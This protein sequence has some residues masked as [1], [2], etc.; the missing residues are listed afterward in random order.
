M[1]GTTSL[2]LRYPFPSET[3]TAQ[4]YQDLAEDIDSV[5]DTLDALR[6]QAR[7]PEMAIV[8]WPGGG[9]SVTQGVTTT[10]TYGTEVVDTAG[11]A[12]LGV[13][14]DRL[15]LSAGIWLINGWASISGG[16]TTSGTQLQFH[17]NAAL[18][19]F[20]RIDNSSF[21][22]KETNGQALIHVAAAGSILQMNAAWF[23]T[24]GPQT[25]FA[26]LHAWKVREL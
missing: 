13:N 3:V 24:G 11:L 26:S 25:W 6:T 7:V 12:N 5:L 1:P 17:L 21:P 4:S 22:S 15:T 14:N 18:H 9:T 16:T 8:Q 20:H 10:L 23:G 19:S 2:G